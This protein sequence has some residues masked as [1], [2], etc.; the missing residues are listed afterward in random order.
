MEKI[1]IKNAKA[2]VTCGADDRVLY[3]AD[4]LIEG[5]T[6]KKIGKTI[7]ENV[8]QVIDGK[9]VIVYPGLINTHHHMIQAFTR[10]IPD[11]EFNKGI[12]LF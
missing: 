2:I 5:N 1:L 6:I 8:N 7:T 4:I 11:L 3:D 12:N 9:D 10:N